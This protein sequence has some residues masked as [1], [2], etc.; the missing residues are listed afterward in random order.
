MLFSLLL[1]MFGLVFVYRTLSLLEKY[2]VLSA[3]NVKFLTV[4]LQIPLLISSFV[5]ELSQLNIIYI[6]IFSLILILQ[7]RIH[8]FFFKKAFEKLHLSLIQQIYLHISSGLSSQTGLTRVFEELSAQQKN[9][10]YP[11][12]TLLDQN[13]C[14]KDIKSPDERAF[15]SD[16][17]HI[18]LSEAN[19]RA[20]LQR[21]RCGLTI[22]KNLRHRSGQILLQ[23]RV[24]AL[25][26]AFL[27]MLMVLL[28]TYYFRFKVFSGAGVVSLVLLL[29]GLKWI[30]KSGDQIKWK[31]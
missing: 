19:I 14:L 16:L 26:C 7:R 20:Q 12:R 4:V 23:T 3:I 18:L 8:T 11:L 15:Y 27:Y 17:R 22:K 24:Q 10:F 9:Y 25:V 29:S 21:F 30:L 1:S 2:E 31:T 28:S 6:G 5:K 13:N